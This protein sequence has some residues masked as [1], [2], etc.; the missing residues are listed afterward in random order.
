MRYSDHRVRN[1][2]ILLAAS[3]YLD[4]ST[5][6][7]PTNT[8]GPVGNLFVIACV[9]GAIAALPGA[10]RTGRRGWSVVFFGFGESFFVRFGLPV[11][12]F[13]LL[14]PILTGGLP[15]GIWF[16]YGA[17]WTVATELFLLASKSYSRRR[18][19]ES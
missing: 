2:L 1:F 10:A 4:W 19:M 17:A 14:Y 3:F 6:S 8:I 9:I 12:L 16:A 13:F 5:N 15:S 11:I 7:N 18:A